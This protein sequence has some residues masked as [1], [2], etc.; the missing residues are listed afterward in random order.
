MLWIRRRGRNLGRGADGWPTQ[1]RGGRGGGRIL[2]NRIGKRG[3]ARNLRG[4]GQ[5]RINGH[6]AG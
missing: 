3:G 2:G 1:V 6:A 5:G 4:V